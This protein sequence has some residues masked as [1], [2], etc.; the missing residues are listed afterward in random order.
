MLAGRFGVFA[1]L[2]GSNQVSA[3][4]LN[5]LDERVVGADEFEW[6]SERA[7]VDRGLAT[8]SELA[9]LWENLVVHGGKSRIG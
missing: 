9:V 6:G 4:D 5:F 7:E 2:L 1:V 8:F 3:V